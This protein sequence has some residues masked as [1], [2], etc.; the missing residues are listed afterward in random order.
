MFEASR[1]AT[2]EKQIA[3]RFASERCDQALRERRRRRVPARL[4]GHRVRGGREAR[5]RSTWRRV[6]NKFPEEGEA[7]VPDAK[8]AMLAK[9]RW[10]WLADKR[11]ARHPARPATDS[12][13]CGS[14]R[15]H[16]PQRVSRSRSTRRP[17]S[18]SRS[19]ACGWRS[20]AT[21]RRRRRSGNHLPKQTE[22]DPASAIWHLLACQQVAQRARDP[23]RATSKDRI[24]LVEKKLEA[25]AATSPTRSRKADP[26]RQ[27]EAEGSPRASCRESI[28]LYED[29]TAEAIKEL[30]PESAATCRDPIP[31]RLGDPR[32]ERCPVAERGRS[33]HSIARACR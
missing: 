24:E 2:R 14:D 13:K 19:A 16:P 20:S 1:S 12:A 7:H 21:R 6:K 28:D 9:A 25:A 29:E 11:L 5:P 3:R 27:Q 18:G 31:S 30:V 4:G 23:A 26:R 15:G 22:K 10:G 32:S 17:R 33:R 8:D